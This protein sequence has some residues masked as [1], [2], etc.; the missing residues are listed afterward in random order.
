VERLAAID[1]SAAG[2]FGF[3]AV[4]CFPDEPGGEKKCD[5]RHTL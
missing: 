4:G 1:R 5:L 3:A 2:P